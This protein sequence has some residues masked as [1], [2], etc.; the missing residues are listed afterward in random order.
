MPTRARGTLAMQRARGQQAFIE[1]LANAASPFARKTPRVSELVRPF[2]H[3]AGGRV[4][5][6]L[7]A[8]LACRR[9]TAP[10]LA[11]LRVGQSS[12][13]SP[14][15][16]TPAR[17]R[18]QPDGSSIILRSKS[19]VAIAVGSTRKDFARTRRGRGRSPTAF[20]CCRICAIASSGLYV[21]LLSYR[22]L[23]ECFGVVIRIA[24]PAQPTLGVDPTAASKGQCPDRL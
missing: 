11:T 8:C 12:W 2:G 21:R 23:H 7:L 10:Y 18:I 24:G 20:T 17:L 4:S 19:A 9:A 3:A 15:R 14:S 16:C 6:R 5:E 22:R 1:K 13:I